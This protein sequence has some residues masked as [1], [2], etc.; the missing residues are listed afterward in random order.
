VNQ[1]RKKIED[2]LGE[3]NQ[4]VEDAIWV[5]IQDIITT[6]G[7]FTADDW[8]LELKQPVIFNDKDTTAFASFKLA[9]A[10]RLIPRPKIPTFI[11]SSILRG[12][13]IRKYREQTSQ[14]AKHGTFVIIEGTKEVDMVLGG[15]LKFSF[16]LEIKSVDTR[17]GDVIRESMGYK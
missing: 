8:I 2:L 1:I 14:V 13:T 6:T 3:Y 11:D 4:K 17:L 7:K 12:A 5:Q 9:G 16:D 15:N 10:V